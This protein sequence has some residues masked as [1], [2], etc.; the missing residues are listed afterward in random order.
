VQIKRQK[1]FFVVIKLHLLEL[2]SLM[3][4]ACASQL[5]VAYFSINRVS[6]SFLIN[7]S[8][9]TVFFECLRNSK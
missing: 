7:S 8:V 9:V 1:Q 2:F 5:Y 3:V 4:L 6:F